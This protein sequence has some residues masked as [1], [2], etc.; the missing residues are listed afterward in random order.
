M[1]P[2]HVKSSKEGGGGDRGEFGGISAIVVALPP[3][4][5]IEENLIWEIRV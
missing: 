1:L 4:P 5:E 3:S 2:Y